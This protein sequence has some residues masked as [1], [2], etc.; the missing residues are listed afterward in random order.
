MVE[1]INGIQL[2][3]LLVK[4]RNL[5]GDHVYLRPR[6]DGNEFFR[7]E[8]ICPKTMRVLGYG[9]TELAALKRSIEDANNS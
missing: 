3:Q 9:L 7:W 2:A 8:L 6:F 4:V 5:F 1:L